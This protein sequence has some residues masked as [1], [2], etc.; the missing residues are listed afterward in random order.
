MSRRIKFFLPFWWDHV[1]SDFDPWEGT[2]TSDKEH[3]KF[4][5]ELDGRTPLMESYFQGLGWRSPKEN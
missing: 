1:Y 4:L 5:W 2:W 3:S